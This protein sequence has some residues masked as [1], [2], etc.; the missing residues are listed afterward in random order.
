MKKALK[1]IFFL[2][3][4]A[5]TFYWSVTNTIAIGQ[6]ALLRTPKVRKLVGIPEIRKYNL[7]QLPGEK[8]GAW[9]TLKDCKYT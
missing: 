8:K 4:Q 6:S 3:S 2:F 1:N 9:E 5:I 7:D